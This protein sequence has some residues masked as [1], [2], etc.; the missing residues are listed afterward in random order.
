MIHL[1]HLCTFVQKVDGNGHLDISSTVICT[2]GQLNTNDLSRYFLPPAMPG[3]PVQKRRN[4]AA[5]LFRALHRCLG[6]FREIYRWQVG[7]VRQSEKTLRTPLRFYI[8]L[9]RSYFGLCFIFD[10]VGTRYP[11]TRALRYLDLLRASDLG[12]PCCWR[13]LGGWI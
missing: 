10:L 7:R 2:S 12:K 9:I 3:K 5:G 11:L 4:A 6:S 1:L 13:V 8:I